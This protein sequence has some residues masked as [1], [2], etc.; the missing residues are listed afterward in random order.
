MNSLSVR[1][2]PLD[3]KSAK[4]RKLGDYA[5]DA[6]FEDRDKLPLVYVLTSLAIAI[7]AILSDRLTLF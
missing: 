6:L 7:S 5:F 4:I 3:A 2:K 1:R